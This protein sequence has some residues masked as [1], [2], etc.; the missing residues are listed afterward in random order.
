MNFPAAFFIPWLTALEKP[1]LEELEII[2]K[3]FSC[4]I[5]GRDPSVELLSTTITS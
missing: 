1:R 3:L 5:A 2:I 4:F